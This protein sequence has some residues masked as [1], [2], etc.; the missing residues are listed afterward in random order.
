MTTSEWIAS[1]VS[2]TTVII[3]YLTWKDSHK[4]KLKKAT[5]KIKATYQKDERLK[6]LLTSLH[7]L[8]AD[9]TVELMVRLQVIITGK[10]GRS[11]EAALL[12]EYL[13]SKHDVD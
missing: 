9:E 8:D 3:G 11:K 2:V 10:N 13:K 1:I 5:N 4:E 12:L 7:Y 6:L